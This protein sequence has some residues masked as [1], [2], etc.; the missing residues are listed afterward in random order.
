MTPTSDTESLPAWVQTTLV[1]PVTSTPE[2]RARIVAAARALPAPRRRFLGPLLPQRLQASSFWRRRG[3]LTGVGG[4]LVTAMFA[5]IVTVRQSE[6]FAWRRAMQA[7]ALASGDSVVPAVVSAERPVVGR[8]LDTLRIVD[9]VLRGRS[10]GGA[11]I[12]ASDARI[13]ATL[14]RTSDGAAEWHARA[15][16]P[17]DMVALALTVDGMQHTVP[18]RH[19][20]R[21]AAP[22]LTP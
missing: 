6:E 17:R 10:L 21:S 8:L 18:I 12:T 14:V 2:A 22:P 11:L 15:L 4:A 19:V 1:A 7:S 13:Q 3:A 5:L 20:R 9:L 16:V